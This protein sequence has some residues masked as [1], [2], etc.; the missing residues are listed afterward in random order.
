MVKVYVECNISINTKNRVF[1]D[2][3]QTFL[4][5]LIEELILKAFPCILDTLCIAAI[6]GELDLQDW[7]NDTV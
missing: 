1:P 6:T 7:W 3:C 2:I 4:H 5:F